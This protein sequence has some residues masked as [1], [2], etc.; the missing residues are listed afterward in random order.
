MAALMLVPA[1]LAGATQTG[2]TPDA[3]A[4][5]A[6]AGTTSHTLFGSTVSDLADLRQKTAEFGHMPII[7]YYFVGLP[8]SNAWSGLGIAN[9]SA[10]VVSFDAQPSAILSG[11]ADSAI[12]HFF[13]TAPRS[14]PIYY[15]YFHEP[16]NNIQK[17]QF[18]AAAYRAAW[19]RVARLARAAHNA[20][21]H[22]DLILMGWDVNPY[23]HR[24]WRNYFP[25]GGIIS[26]VSWDVFPDGGYTVEPPAEWMGP[27]VKV[28]K[29]AGLH[30][31]FAEFNTTTIP[32]RPAW[33]LSI[34]T[35]CRSVGA[36]FCTLFDSI[37]V[38]G[39]AAHGGSYV[40]RDKASISAWRHVVQ[41]GG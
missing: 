35:Y 23:S 41:N 4:S 33:L 1:T 31:G 19:E 6:R 26:T 28:S 40:I 11:A 27:E 37:Q 20:D 30:F 10:V 18:T 8:P 39:L 24:N 29:A 21:L 13:D 2:A 38:G 9:H 5:Q 34:G 7:H 16:E 14:F 22:S 15:C 32:G 17:G 3:G 36:V 12:A 25:T